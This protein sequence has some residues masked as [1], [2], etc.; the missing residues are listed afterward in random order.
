VAAVFAVKKGAPLPKSWGGRPVVDG[1][2]HD[3]I[4]EHGRGVVIGLRAKGDAKGD[5]SGFVIAGKEAAR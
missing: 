3:A 5:E 4:F 2:E 1:D